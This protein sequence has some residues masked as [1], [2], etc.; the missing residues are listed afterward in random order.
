[1]GEFY[2]QI[3]FQ[4]SCWKE[5]QALPKKIKSQVD[6]ILSMLR[7]N[8]Y[9]EILKT[10]KIRGKENH[11]RLRIGDYRL[12]YCPKQELLIVRV[13]RLGHRK[14]VYRHF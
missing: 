12:I 6:E 9:S 11:F 5:Y 14:D 2:Y 10:K 3:V 1:M 4:K 7:I 8:P 13:I